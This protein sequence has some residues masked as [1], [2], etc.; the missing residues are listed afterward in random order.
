LTKFMKVKFQAVSLKMYC[1]DLN[2]VIQAPV[3]TTPGVF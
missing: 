1:K 2:S 3:P